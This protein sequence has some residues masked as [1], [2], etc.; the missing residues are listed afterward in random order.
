MTTSVTIRHVGRQHE[1]RYHG[2]GEA[3]DDDELGEIRLVRIVR[4]LVVDEEVDAG[5]EDDDADDDRDDHESEVEIAHPI[6]GVSIPV[7][8]WRCTDPI[9][10]SRVRKFEIEFGDFK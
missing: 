3:E 8:D 10:K 7:A 6:R 4:V 5:D 9:E 1:N 2:D